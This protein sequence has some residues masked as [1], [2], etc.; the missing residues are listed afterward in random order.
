MTDARNLPLAL[1]TERQR[2]S[3]KLRRWFR[4]FQQMVLIVDWH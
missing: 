1:R 4:L 2:R 3:V